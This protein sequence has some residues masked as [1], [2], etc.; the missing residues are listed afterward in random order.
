MLDNFSIITQAVAIVKYTGQISLTIDSAPYKNRFKKIFGISNDGLEFYSWIPQSSFNNLI[1]LQPNQYYLVF[2]DATTDNPIVFSRATGF[3]TANYRNCA[4]WNG[5]S[6]NVTVVGTNGGQSYYG[7]YDMDGNVSEWVDTIEDNLVKRVY[8]GGN[9]SISSSLTLKDRTVVDPSFSSDKLGFRVCS[10]SLSSNKFV[11]VEDVHN[12]N[13]VSGYGGVNYKYF[14][15]KY[16]ITNDEYVIFLN[17]TA[18]YDDYNSYNSSMGSNAR[19]GISRS[20]SYGS[21]LYTSRSNMGN[22]PIVFVNWYSAA[23]YCNWLH[24]NKPNSR[25]QNLLSTESGSYLLNGANDGIIPKDRNASYWIPSEDEW[26]KAG[27]YKGYG[28]NEG[29]WNYS[30]QTDSIP[31]CVNSSSV[32]SGPYCAYNTDNICTPTPTVTPTITATPTK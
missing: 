10:D 14:I 19:G 2:S 9:W 13:D 25:L 16:E 32:G 4:I 23:R 24:N 22:K 30:T 18:S 12:A 15:S 1:K 26:I 5:Q 17:S 3:N 27:Y 31:D 11:A 21:Y 7:C 20:G 28:V 8:R 6:G 29:Y